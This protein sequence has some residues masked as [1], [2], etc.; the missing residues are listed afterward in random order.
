MSIREFSAPRVSRDEITGYLGT[1]V[2]EGLSERIDKCLEIAMPMLSYRVCFSEYPI[3]VT[4]D[5]VDFGFTKA[6]SRNLA[7]RLS[8]CSSAIIFVAT[9]GIGIDRLM[10]RYS[11]T[12]PADALIISAIGNERIE[13]LCDAF[14]D[15][16]A[17]IEAERGRCVCQRFS[18]GYG[19]LDLSFER[20]IFN[21][22]P[23]SASIGVTLSDSLLMTPVKSVSAIIGI[24]LGEK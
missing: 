1:R 9:V 23:I 3:T 10:S 5:K 13:A 18:P 20:E 21:V 2:T 19:D 8:G 4:D 7:K 22:M 12:S 14:C 6:V 24:K 16:T 11:V 17:K 15:E